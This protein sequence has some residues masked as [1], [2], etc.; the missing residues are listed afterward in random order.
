LEKFLDF[1][2]LQPPQGKKLPFSPRQKPS[3]FPASPRPVSFLKKGVKFLKLG[4]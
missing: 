2:F 4:D 1:A 3:F